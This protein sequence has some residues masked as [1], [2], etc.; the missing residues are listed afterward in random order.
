MFP[1]S[2]LLQDGGNL[3]SPHPS[4]RSGHLSVPREHRRSARE[5]LLDRRSSSGTAGST[6]S[7][8]CG[9]GACAAGL[10]VPEDRGACAT[11]TRRCRC[12]R[13]DGLATIRR[14]VHLPGLALEGD[15][16]VLDVGTGSGYRAAVL[17]G[18]AREVHSIERIPEL[19]DRARVSLAAAGYEAVHVAARQRPGSAYPRARAVRRVLPWRRLPRDAAGSAGAGPGEGRRIALPIGRRHQQLC[20][21]ASGRSKG[22]ASSPRSPCVSSPSSGARTSFRNNRI[23]DHDVRRL[24]G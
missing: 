22:R 5:R 8:A 14:C 1:R 18:L 17:A 13:A 10:F 9:N 7:G 20:M 12:P 3:G 2:P 6:T 11:R 15:E 24:I 21:L 23:T 16:R 4:T 19:A